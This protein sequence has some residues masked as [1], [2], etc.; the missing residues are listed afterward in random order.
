MDGAMPI[1]ERGA[2]TRL[3]A[4]RGDVGGL[5]DRLAAGD[6]MDTLRANGPATQWA[7][8]NDEKTTSEMNLEAADHR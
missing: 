6:I 3:D 7:R 2:V 4:F 1:C 5:A 8:E